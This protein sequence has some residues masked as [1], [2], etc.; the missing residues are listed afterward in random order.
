M[1][2]TF[3]K[4][5][6]RSDQQTK[7][8]WLIIMTGVSMAVVVLIWLAV[9]KIPAAENNNAQEQPQFS[10]FAIFIKGLGVI[11]SEVYNKFLPLL[12]PGRSTDI[13]L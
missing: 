8:F 3:I 6:R 1:L 9:L 7:K 13:K 12:I 10:H 4:K 11:G 5:I 2:F